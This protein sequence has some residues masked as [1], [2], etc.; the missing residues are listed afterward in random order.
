MFRTFVIVFAIVS[1]QAWA[2]EE[3]LTG[4]QIHQRII[5]NTMIDPD[6]NPPEAKYFDSDGFVRVQ[7]QDGGYKGVWMIIDNQLCVG[8]DDEHGNIQ[9]AKDCATVKI[10]GT[11]VT[12]SN[13]DVLTLEPGNTKNITEFN[14]L[15]EQ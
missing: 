4:D 7:D 10:K 14:E 8:Y 1:S 12:M 2:G 6:S 13:G 3:S 11:R 5:G 9:E 15:S